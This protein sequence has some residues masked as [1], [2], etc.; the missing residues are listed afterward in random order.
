MHFKELIRRIG[1]L[2]V[3]VGLLALAAGVVEAGYPEKPITLIVPWPPGGASDV[4]PRTLLKP[5]SEELKQPVII[6]NRPGAAG[7]TGTLEVE[8][9]TPDGYTIGTYSFSQALTQYTSPNPTHLANVIPIAKVMYSPATLTLNA[10]LPWNSVEEFIRYAKANPGKIR[11]ANSGKGASAHIFGEA[12]DRIAGIKEIHVPF[13]GYAP[14]V[15]AVAGGH[16]EAT[17]IPVGDVHAMVKGGKFKLL[18][19]AAQ[20]RHFLY[21]NVPTMKELKLDLDIGNWVAFIAPKGVPEEII[22]TLDRAIEKALQRPEVIKA[23]QEM[24]N[25]MVYQD[26]KTFAEWLKPHDA[27]IRSLVDSLGLWAAPRK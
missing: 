8:K 16:I 1:G 26:H 13:N 22:A 4:T 5:M 21:P 23:W 11:N 18:A 3:F 14:A 9:A 20:E 2:F 24:G 7:V 10:N 19:V 6:V 25:V 15:A 17:C 12:F 27:Q